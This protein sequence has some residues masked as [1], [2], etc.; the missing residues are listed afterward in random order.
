[1]ANVPPTRLSNYDPRVQAYLMRDWAQSLAPEGITDFLTI[2]LM[3]QQSG[4]DPERWNTR[5]SPQRQDLNR[6]IIRRIDRVVYGRNHMKKPQ[7]YKYEFFMLEETRDRSGNSVFAH[8]HAGLALLNHERKVFIDKWP[9]IQ[10]SIEKLV[11]NRGLYPD[12]SRQD[13]DDGVVKYIVKNAL[14]EA[15]TILTRATMY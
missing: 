10:W 3:K 13:A 7:Y 11:E 2:S 9:K 4:T 15:Q 1:M 6:D 14:T 5:T 8:V 12:V